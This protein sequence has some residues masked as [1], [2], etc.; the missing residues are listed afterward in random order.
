M[1]KV[2][3]RKF[4][5]APKIYADTTK[6]TFWLYDANANLVE[7]YH[8]VTGSSIKQDRFTY[9]YSA[10]NKELSQTRDIAVY[11]LNLLHGASNGSVTTSY[12]ER[13]LT[14]SVTLS[15]YGEHA[16]QTASIQ[17]QITN[18]HTNS[19]SRWTLEQN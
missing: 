8:L 10:T 5:S 14:A 13:D 3:Q 15:D 12:N 16:L 7:S 18:T 2:V 19:L 9:S 4:A 11:G 1:G 17:N 6:E